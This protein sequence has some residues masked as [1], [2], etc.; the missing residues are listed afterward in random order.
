MAL[1]PP[2]YVRWLVD[3]AAPGFW[4]IFVDRANA[5]LDGLAVDVTSWW[6]TQRGNAALAGASPES[7]HLLGAA[8]DVSGRDFRQAGQ[9]L[10]AQG[11][12]V[13][14]Y[15]RHVHAQA[16]PAGTARRVGLLQALGL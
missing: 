9:R 6:R 1:P 12:V 7:Q 13:V 15:P 10:R 14:D 8:I 5:A 16:W 3:Q 11:F 2:L 4:P